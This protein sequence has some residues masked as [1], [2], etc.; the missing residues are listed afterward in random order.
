MALRLRPKP[1][2]LDPVARV[3]VECD[4]WVYLLVTEG[5]TSG[6]EAPQVVALLLVLASWVMGRTIH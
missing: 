6:P 4:W 2:P 1:L 5:P 3:R